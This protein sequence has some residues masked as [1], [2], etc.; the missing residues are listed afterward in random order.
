MRRALFV[1]VSIC[2]LAL[3]PASAQ[4]PAGDWSTVFEGTNLDHFNVVGTANC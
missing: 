2:T 3:G 4:K 1:C